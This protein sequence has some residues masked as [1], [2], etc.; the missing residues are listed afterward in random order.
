MRRVRV[1]IT[2]RVQGVGFRDW[3]ERQALARNLGGW[4]RNRVDGSVEAVF[5]GNPPQVRE[6]LDVIW[7]GP[8]A[9]QVKGVEVFDT[10]EQPG[11]FRMLPTA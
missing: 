4:V 11:D 2:G 3:T 1:V 7:D 8:R 5:C 9:S 10:D 6:M